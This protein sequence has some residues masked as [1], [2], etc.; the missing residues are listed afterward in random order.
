[1]KSKPL[2]P[3]EVTYRCSRVVDQEAVELEILDLV[4]KVT[5]RH[6][7]CRVSWTAKR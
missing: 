5:A 6:L 4:C 3:A 7:S 1:M 2:P